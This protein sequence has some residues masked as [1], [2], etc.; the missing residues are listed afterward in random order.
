[1]TPLSSW[2]YQS[3]NNNP[4]TNTDLAGAAIGFIVFG[5]SYIY[6]VIY[7]FYDIN[8]S[9]NKYAEDVEDDRNVIASLGVSASTKSEWEAELALKLSG[10]AKEDGWD[11]QLLGAAANLTREEYGAYM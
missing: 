1:M 3:P 10:K 11:D 4:W 6:V 7:I 5:I 9:R 8:R 2:T